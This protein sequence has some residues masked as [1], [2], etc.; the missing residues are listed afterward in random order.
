[1][2]PTTEARKQYYQ[3][4]QKYLAEQLPWAFLVQPKLLL[5]HKSELKNVSKGNQNIIGLP[6]DNPVF[7]AAD[8]QKLQ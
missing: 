5:V 2:A 3:N 4:L 7:N 6:W 1:M 8:W